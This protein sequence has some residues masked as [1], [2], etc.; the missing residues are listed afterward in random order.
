MIITKFH[1]LLVV[2]VCGWAFWFIWVHIS[3]GWPVD[4]FRRERMKGS[5]WSRVKCRAEMFKRAWSE[6]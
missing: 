4:F 6:R 3:D 2:G 1:L 5:F